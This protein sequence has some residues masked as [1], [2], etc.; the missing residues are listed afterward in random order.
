[1]G[2]AGVLK[3]KRK[4]MLVMFGFFSFEVL[5]FLQFFATEE[6]AVQKVFSF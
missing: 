1:M 5:F 2:N 4:K 3:R 6:S